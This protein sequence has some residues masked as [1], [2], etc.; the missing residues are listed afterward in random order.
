MESTILSVALPLAAFLLGHY[1]VLL[2]APAPKAPDF[3]S[4]FG[5]GELVHYL[6]Q[7]LANL[8]ASASGDTACSG[9][10]GYSASRSSAGDSTA[11]GYA[12]EVPDAAGWFSEALSPVG[13]AMN[14]ERSCGSGPGGRPGDLLG[15]PIQCAGFAESL[16][17]PVPPAH[18]GRAGI[19]R[20]LSIAMR[21][22][23]S[24]AVD[25]HEYSPISRKGKQAALA[26]Q[27]RMINIRSRAFFSFRPP[28]GASWPA[29]RWVHTI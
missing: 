4:T 11:L 22:V 25:E 13:W 7:Q 27:N 9:E 14:P 23:T 26:A 20:F 6:L 18:L 24:A 3:P 2:P 12:G 5:H 1:H 8:S 29:G 16:C 15:V 19:Q 21:A 28:L 17:L 10:R